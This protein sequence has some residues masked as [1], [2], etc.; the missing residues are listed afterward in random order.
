MRVAHD[1]E[2]GHA[3]LAQAAA[4]NNFTELDSLPSPAMDFL[5]QEDV[6]KPVESGRRPRFCSFG[7]GLL[8]QALIERFHFLYGLQWY[9]DH[10][11]LA[12]PPLPLVP[13]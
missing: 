11:R 3:A 10:P 9:R 1:N 13:E 4:R 2:H 8:A 5:D 7:W 12:P 6:N